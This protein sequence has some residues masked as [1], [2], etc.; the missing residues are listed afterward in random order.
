[1]FAD[2]ETFERLIAA[3]DAL[4]TAGHVTLLN[5]HLQHADGH[6]VLCDL[7]GHLLPDGVTSV[8]T[9]VD[10]TER[11]RQ[12]QALLRLQRLYSALMFEGEVLLQARDART[13]LNRTCTAL[14]QATP[15]HA[16]WIAQPD[17]T[18][19][20]Q[21]L[22]QAGDGAAALHT[23]DIRLSDAEHAPL[24]ARAWQT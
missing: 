11:E 21:V 1:M 4:A 2:T 16:V 14:T 8:W 9:F 19:R 3:Y 23:L 12:A 10:I 17:Q 5:V 22:A 6:A 7:H 15:F 20:M 24:V 18:G 13:M